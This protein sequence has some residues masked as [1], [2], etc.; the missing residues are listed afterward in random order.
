MVILCRQVKNQI[1]SLAFILLIYL[2]FLFI[3]KINLKALGA[4]QRIFEILDTVPSI[5]LKTGF[6]PKN[7]SDDENIFDGSLIFENVNFSYPT[8]VESKVIKDVS[9]VVEKGKT[10][11]LV[12]PSG[13]GKSTIFALI[14]RFYDP[15]SGEIKIGPKQLNLKALNLNWVHSKIA[16]VSQEPVLFGGMSKSL[17]LSF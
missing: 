11:A 13:G 4:S 14:E 12:G 7:K 9:L 16:M 6:K 15:D 10:L 17:F 2:K 1:L 3:F 5:H 8:R